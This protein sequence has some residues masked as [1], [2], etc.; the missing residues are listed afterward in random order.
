MLEFWQ[1]RAMADRRSR[2][3]IRPIAGSTAPGDAASTLRKRL[4]AME[5][6]LV[7]ERKDRARDADTFAKMLKRTTELEAEANALR[8]RV[9]ELE[10]ILERASGIFDELERG[11]RAIVEF[12][13]RALEDA[14]A[15]ILGASGFDRRVEPPPIPSARTQAKMMRTTM[16]VEISELDE[17][18][19]SL[20][21]PR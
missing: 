20:R 6:E 1:T 10:Q 8:D 2:P 7:R 18:R 14:R 5:D 15:Q 4:S 17:I 13:S 12:R 21:P 16:D 11:D 9:A 19:R 3:S